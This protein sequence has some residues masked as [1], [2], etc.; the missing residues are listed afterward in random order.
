MKG[1]FTRDTFD[2]NN[3]YSRVLM[4]QG[5]V[6]LDADWNEQAAIMLHQLRS[7][8]VDLIGPAWAVG[9]GFQL[10]KSTEGNDFT[11]KK[12]RYYVDGIACELDADLLFLDQPGVGEPDRNW[13]T[14][15]IYLVYID[16]WERLVTAAERDALREVALGGADTT[17]RAQVAWQ[18]RLLPILQDAAGGGRPENCLAAREMLVKFMERTPPRLYAWAKDDA[19]D[20]PCEIAPD[21][22]Y[23]GP[24]N[25]LYRVEIHDPGV[26]NVAGGA[27]TFKWS[28]DNGS[29]LFPVLD[30]DAGDE[31]LTVKL[32]HL[33]RDERSGLAEGQWVELV[34]DPYLYQSRH[35][36]LL[37]VAAVDEQTLT[38]RLTGKAAN[39]AQ[40]AEG[41]VLRRWDQRKGVNG[42]GVITVKESAGT[43]QNAIVLEDGVTIR[44]ESGGHYRT[45]DY[46]LIPARTATADVEWPTIT[47]TSGKPQ[48]LPLEPHGVEHHY[49]LLGRLEPDDG[50][51]VT[52]CRCALPGGLL[53]CPE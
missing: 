6:Q 8:A 23:R 51:L 25:Q 43:T 30:V 29:V 36:G 46:W 20:Q 28:R 37:R 4:Q 21:A 41:R 10:E 32:A 48:P 15:R 12:G 18:V 40:K 47:D 44:F 9:G 27:P 16:A 3:H 52:D 26:L 24:E 45:G 34:D 35:D 5:R 19:S 1:D 53:Q 49:G 42:A 13:N 33:G 22:S 39:R 31:Q 11:I 38:V 17:A 14:D 2:K 50:W 7:L